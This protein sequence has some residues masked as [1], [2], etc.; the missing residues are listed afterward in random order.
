MRHTEEE[1]RREAEGIASA[2]P[3]RIFVGSSEFE[4]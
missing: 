1:V 4:L 2:T 3:L